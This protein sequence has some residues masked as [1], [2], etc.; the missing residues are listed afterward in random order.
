MIYGDCGSLKLTAG[1]GTISGNTGNLILTSGCSL[2]Q[3]YHDLWE[4][5]PG[6][7]INIT[8]PEP[9]YNNCPYCDQNYEKKFLKCPNCGAGEDKKFK[10]H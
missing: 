2:P 9:Q 1:S 8:P 7:I 6:K 5:K 4:A 10:R 3:N